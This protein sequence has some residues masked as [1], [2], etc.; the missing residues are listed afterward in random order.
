MDDG[1]DGDGAGEEGCV[2]GQG[3]R[4]RNQV[5]QFIGGV[6]GFGSMDMERADWVDIFF[7]PCAGCGL[8]SG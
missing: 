4:Q 5:R 1:A 2:G 8:L 3:D 7:R 6:D